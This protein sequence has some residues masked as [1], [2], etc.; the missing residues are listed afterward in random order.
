MS[1]VHAEAKVAAAAGRTA[2]LWTIE[3]TTHTARRTP[4]TRRR[5]FLL[6]TRRLKPEPTE[7]ATTAERSAVRPTSIVTAALTPVVT[8]V[9]A[10]AVTPVVTAALAAAVTPGVR[11]ALAA[12]VTAARRR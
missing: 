7:R 6:T 8:A 9:L 5:P 12:A 10:A 2:P 1:A 11:A 3:T 4:L